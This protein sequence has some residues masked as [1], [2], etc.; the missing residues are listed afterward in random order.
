[1]NE[2]ELDQEI[3]KIIVK[4]MGLEK[5]E[6]GNALLRTIIKNSASTIVEFMHER[7][8][9]RDQQIA[10]AA[11]KPLEKILDEQGWN[12][13]EDCNDFMPTNDEC[14]CENCDAMF[15]E[16]C[17]GYVY[18]GDGEYPSESAYAICK[19]CAKP[20]PKQDEN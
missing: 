17:A 15:H 14:I 8:A 19:R 2:E 1:M 13:C 16:G 9:S 20:T 5:F 7:D 6:D 3:R 4:Y 11:R 10:L 18:N 12:R